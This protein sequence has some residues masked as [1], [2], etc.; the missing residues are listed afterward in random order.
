M[1]SF[2]IFFSPADRTVPDI[3]RRGEHPSL[4]YFREDVPDDLWSQVDVIVG[5]IE[6]DGDVFLDLLAV[7][8]HVQ[9]EHCREAGFAVCNAEDRVDKR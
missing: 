2:L 3:Q 8:L 1:E 4:V 9:S 7:S 6:N 5:V